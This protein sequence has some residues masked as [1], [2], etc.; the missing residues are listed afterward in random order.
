MPSWFLAEIPINPST[1]LQPT[2]DVSGLEDSQDHRDLPLWLNLKPLCG[3]TEGTFCRQKINWTV[4]G[5]S[6]K[7][8]K[9]MTLRGS[10]GFLISCKLRSYILFKKWYFFPADFQTFSYFKGTKCPDW[11]GSYTDRSTYLAGMGGVFSTIKQKSD[12]NSHNSQSH[13]RGMGGSTLQIQGG[14][15]NPWCKVRRYAVKEAKL[16]SLFCFSTFIFSSR[17]ALGTED[18]Q[19]AWSTCPNESRRHGGYSS[20]RGCLAL[21]HARKRHSLYTCLQGLCC[22]R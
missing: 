12:F 15:R 11:R 20:R 14:L 13:W 18:I 21:Q 22:G 4:I 10:I 8:A 7:R 1:L 5:Y 19:F 6:W 9:M 16:C 2:E 3:P 17:I